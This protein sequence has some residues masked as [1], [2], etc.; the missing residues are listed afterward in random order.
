MKTNYL[1]EKTQY[2]AEIPDFQRPGKVRKRGPNKVLI[3]P[4]GIPFVT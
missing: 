1:I 4:W 2:G 3:Q